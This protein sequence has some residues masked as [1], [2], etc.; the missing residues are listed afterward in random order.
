M[1][2]KYCSGFNEYIYSDWHKKRKRKSGTLSLLLNEGTFSRLSGG[3]E[4]V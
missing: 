2:Q 4:A 3:K 1:S